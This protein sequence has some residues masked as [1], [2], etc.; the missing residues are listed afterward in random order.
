MATARKFGW[1]GATLCAGILA[2]CATGLPGGSDDTGRIRI[3]GIPFH[4]QEGFRCGP[5]S[6]AMMLAW[7]GVDIT[8]AKLENQFA[9][10]QRDPRVNLIDSARRFGRIAYPIV[11][12]ESLAKELK[13]GHP[14]LVLE[15]LGVA[16]QPM[17]NC[18]VAI[19]LDPAAQRVVLNAGGEAGK[20]I[21]YRLMERLWADNAFWGLVVL[22][23]DELPA[24][25]AEQSYVEAVRGLE[26]AGRYWEA[27]RAYDTALSLWP[28]NVDATM[29]V[30]TSLYLLGDPQGA[31]EAF[32]TA[33]A[34]APDPKPALEAL[35]H[36][37]NEMGQNEEALATARKAVTI[38]APA[39]AGQVAPG[40]RKGR[41]TWTKE[42][43]TTER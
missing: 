14:V 31:V 43:A 12:M 5:A 15:N 29:G 32:R 30:G 22:R 38:T 35:A 10:D 23:P 41:P 21:S 7:A 4:S 18:P 26:R 28:G 25:V 19:G 16:S 17:W 6:M 11:G 20:S 2:G 3:S 27:V 36:V 34:M 1:V 9:R 39:P 40:L 37:L 24:T 33:A 13:A 8:P 42:A